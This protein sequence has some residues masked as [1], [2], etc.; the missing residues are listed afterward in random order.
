VSY[1]IIKNHEGCIAV[2]S[3]PG[4]G[5]AFDLYI[6]ASDREPEPA[7]SANR[8]KKEGTF[9]ILLMDD[10]QMILDVGERILTRMGHRVRR[11]RNGEEAIELYRNASASG[12]GFDLVIMDLTIPGGKGGSETIGD[13]RVIDPDVRAIVSSGYSNNP[14]M[15]NFRE[16]GFCGVIVKPYR[17]DDL[18]H[19]LEECVR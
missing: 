15:A 8:Q 2:K 9:H 1:S 7:Q 17:Y 10:E 18:K 13:L 6:P 4:K 11:A 12:D 5:T 19:A 3:E 16:Y 14:V